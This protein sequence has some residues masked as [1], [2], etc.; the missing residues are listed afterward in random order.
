MEIYA[1]EFKSVREKG[2]AAKAIDAAF[3]TG[4]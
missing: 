3:G 1:H 2:S 4:P